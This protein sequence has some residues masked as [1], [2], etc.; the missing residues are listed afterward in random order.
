[1]VKA[2]SNKELG[3]RKVTLRAIEDYFGER[4][5]ETSFKKILARIQG[6]KVNLDTGEEI[7][8]AWATKQNLDDKVYVKS[9]STL[10]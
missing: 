9:L 2:L 4:I 1:M 10:G 6:K 3:K 5:S 7:K 8:A